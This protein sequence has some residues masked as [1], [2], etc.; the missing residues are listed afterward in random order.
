MP[1][2][3]AFP[4][5]GNPSSSE[6]A[7]LHQGRLLV[8]W[9]YAPPVGH[10]IEAFKFAQGYALANPH[11]EVSLLLNARSAP[12]LID[13]VP[14][15]GGVYLIDMD[16]FAE[17]S[18]PRPSLEAVPQDWNYLFVDPRQNHPMPGWPP[19]NHYRADA[20][21]YF[22]AKHVWDA[23]R[24]PGFPPRIQRPLALQ[25]S[26]HARAYAD[27]ALTAGQWPRL[28][29]LFAPGGGLLSSGGRG[30][31]AR[32]PRPAF[33]RTLIR[34]LLAE[35]PN[36]QLVLLGALKVSH[37]SHG[38]APD[39]LAG[40]EAE[41]RPY[42]MPMTPASSTNSPWPSA[43][44]CTSRRIPASPSPCSA[45]ARPGSRSQVARCSSIG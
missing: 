45:S 9:V 40:L 27:S 3:P 25:L 6:P 8:D 15:L 32:T 35:Y 11:L 38:V 29:L 17:P 4:S 2:I 39:D 22:R 19:Y 5:T 42:S 33:W 16:D 24:T 23:G 44:I 37:P 34:A 43:V 18:G 7:S 28:S 10:A 30:P 21:R 36:A 1:A 41:F 31:F 14:G 20:R 13:C 26:A 12:E